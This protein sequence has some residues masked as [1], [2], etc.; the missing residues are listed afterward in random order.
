MKNTFGNAVS[1][2]IFGESHGPAVG[3]VLDGLAAG[4]PVD[5]AVIAA[6]MDRRRARGDGLSTARTE[7]DAV[8][9][10]SGVYEGRTTGTAVTLMIR[11]LNTRSGD[12]AKTADLLRPGHADYTAYAKYE[13]FQDARGGGHFS[14]RITAA[15]VAAGTICETVLNGLGVKVY[16]HIA[17][18]AGVQDAPLSSAA[19]LVMPDPQPGHFA[20][21]D[22][23]KEEAMQAAIRAAGS[24]GDSVGGILETIVTGLPAGIG[25]PWFD[26]VESELAH[27]MFAIPACKGI[28][29]GAGFGFAAMHGSEAN[30]PF[31]MRDGKIATATNKNGGINGGITNGMP[32]VFRTVLKPTPSIY[33]Q[34]HTVDYIGRTDA[35]LQIK[36]RH[37][38]CIV[39]RAAVVQNSLTAF[40]LLDLLTVRY[41]TL[42]QKHGFPK[43]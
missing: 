28:E 19:G 16:T 7:A 33:K 39:P 36:G 6:A 26:S 43:V 38:P 8:E 4:L 15:S 18:C 12:Y 11:N 37:D 13:G 30:D 24:E 40:G 25:E 23:S 3:A 31:T 21:L 34:Q 2:T 10:L 27:L 35:E 41:G 14:G 9:F 17:E 1:M 42:A 22:A 29:F 5:E 20:L 32:I